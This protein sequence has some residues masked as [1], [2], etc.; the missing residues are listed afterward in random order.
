[1]CQ[2]RPSLRASLRSRLRV[3][4]FQSEM[5][6]SGCKI[7]S[8]FCVEGPSLRP[9][10]ALFRVPPFPRME[11]GNRKKKQSRQLTTSPHLLNLNDADVFVGTKIP[12]GGC[13][14][15]TNEMRSDDK[16]V[17]EERPRVLH[18][19]NDKWPHVKNALLILKLSKTLGS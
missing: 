6:R 17:S 1:M 2:I 13:S 11:K 3:G 15:Q 18:P 10:G 5:C 7:Q 9:F 4:A 19:L 16:L 14:C 12:A 8:L